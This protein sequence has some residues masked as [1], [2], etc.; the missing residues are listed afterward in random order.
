MREKSHGMKIALFVGQIY[1]YTQ[2]EIIKGVYEECKKNNDELHLFSFYV[3]ND[4]GFDVGEYEYIKRMDLSGFDGFI[5]YASAFYNPYIRGVLAKRLKESGKP[6]VSLDS[7][8]K[9]FFNILSCNGEAMEE[10]VEHVIS[11]HDVK[12]VNFVGG[13]ADSI[14]AQYRLDACKKVMNKHG[15]KLPGERIYAG[16]YYVDSG[17]KAYEYFKEH[18]LMDADA[19]ICVND[20]SAMGVFY[21]LTEDGYRVPEDYIITGFD[22]IPQAAY[23]QPSITSIKRFENKIGNTA[24]NMLHSKKGETV[25]ITP[26]LEIGTSC[27]P[28]CVVDSV[29]REGYLREC[30]KLSMDNSRYAGYVSD[31][32]A[33][34]MAYRSSGE[35]YDMLP[36]YQKK[37]NIPIMSIILDNGGKHLEM[38]YHYNIEENERVSKQL[39]RNEVY[40]NPGEGNLYIYSSLH[41]GSS[42]FGYAITTNYGAALETE[43]YHMFINNISNMLE[44]ARKYNAQENYIDRLKDLSYYDP[45]T[46]LYNRLG[47]FNKAEVDFEIGRQ[48]DR[49]MYIIFADMDRLKVINDTMGHK[50]GDE[51]IVDFANILS[52]NIDD[53]E[54]VM[55]FGGDEFVIFGK[56]QSSDEV[57]DK[58]KNIQESIRAFNEKGKYSPYILGASMGYTMIAPDT[59]KTL[60]SFIEAADSKMYMAKQ[61]KRDQ[62]SGKDRRSGRDRRVNDRRALNDPLDL[63]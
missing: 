28:D 30:I 29:K 41:Y 54:L 59:D 58:I 56:A 51:Y 6:C 35:M 26:R 63:N 23:N 4:E 27:C 1:I 57:K 37:F 18:D 14:D 40:N 47:F 38:P 42:Y 48:T 61:E 60:F 11:K 21:R 34:F 2:R 49:E 53:N 55:R 25:K 8:D 12:T 52:S 3:S 39:K 46:K 15:L 62:R 33:D 43:L 32:S 22:N 9:D 13:P 50:M 7:Y 5:L 45:L 36:D 19:F 20:P 44:S 16:N 17:Y 10:L 24:Y 31:C